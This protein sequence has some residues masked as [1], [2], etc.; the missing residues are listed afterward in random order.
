METN[1]STELSP[2]SQNWTSTQRFDVTALCVRTVTNRL[3]TNDAAELEWKKKFIASIFMHFAVDD[4]KEQDVLLSMPGEN[5]DTLSFINLIKSNFVESED[6]NNEQKKDIRQEIVFDLLLVCLGLVQN[7][8]NNSI[9]SNHKRL[10]LKER[11]NKVISDVKGEEITDT[12]LT[13]NISTSQVME[14]GEYDSRARAILFEIAKSIDVP[15]N[16][17]LG[18]EKVIAQH[19]YFFQHKGQHESTN[20]NNDD[21]IDSNIKELQNSAKASLTIHEK[22]KKKWHWMATGVGVVVGATAIGLTGGLAAPFVAA[23]IGAI[24]GVGVVTAAASSVVLVTS[25]FGIAGGGLAGYKM[26]KRTQGLKEFGF[27]RIVQDDSI[28]LIPSLH[29]NIVISGY[30]LSGSDDGVIK[31]WLPTFENTSNYSDTFA[32]SFDTEIIR[33]LGRAFHRFLAE[34]AV[35]VAASQAI[36]QTVFATLASALLIPAALMKAGDLIDNPWALGVDRAHKAG[37]VLADV[38]IEGVQGKRPTVLIGFSLGA[39]VIWSCLR[40]LAK[41]EKY[42][43]IDSVIIIG[44]PIDSASPKWEKVISVVSRRFVNGYATNDVVLGLIYRMHSLDLNVAGLGAVNFD[45][46]ENYDLTKFTDGHLGYCNPEAMEAILQ[47]IGLN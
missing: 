25:L 10:N 44:A 6:D 17:I 20:D 34:Q 22:E 28:P 1:L 37:L 27:T 8:T 40:E 2:L 36:K 7:N 24:T 15:V 46:V 18:L 32:L 21:E 3:W 29:V 11:L 19:I 26:H 42:G 14:L 31:P 41:R 4:V 13:S 43:L 30:L 5:N 45:R 38:L 33:S 47:E 9:D 16:I 12:L 35:K 39:L 23:G